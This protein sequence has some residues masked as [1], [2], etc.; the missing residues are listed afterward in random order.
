MDEQGTPPTVAPRKSTGADRWVKLGFLVVASGIVFFIWRSLRNPSMPGWGD[1]L[2]AALVQARAEKR[3]IVV[4]FMNRPPGELD[5][6][7]RDSI[8]RKPGNQ[9]A[10]RNGNFIRVTIQLPSDLQSEPAKRYKLK[11]LPTL[12]LLG[13]DGKELNRREGRLGELDFRSGFLDCAKV[14]RD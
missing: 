14:L 2:D 6:W 8:I 5:R 13:P 11:K 12:I 7:N 4:F 10:L 9:Q 3:R 1:D